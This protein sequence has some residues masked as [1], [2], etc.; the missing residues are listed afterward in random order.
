MRKHNA[1]IV[2][3]ALLLGQEIKADGH[4][5]VLMEGV[6]TSARFYN[7]KHLFYKVTKVEDGVETPHLIYCDMNL[8]SFIYMCSQIPEQDIFTIG[9]QNALIEMAQ[10][11]A[12]KRTSLI[13][14]ES[15]LN[16]IMANGMRADKLRWAQQE[17][18]EKKKK[19]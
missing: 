4:T 2:L 5:Y 11:K 3:K 14:D 10:E 18:E 16:N 15:E 8:W 19:P 7:A 12:A 17:A 9:A 13:S 1:E 6:M